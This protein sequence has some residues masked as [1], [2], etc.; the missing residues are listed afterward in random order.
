MTTIDVPF[1]IRNAA[2]VDTT[3]MKHTKDRTFTTRDVLCAR[4][5]IRSK[6]G[7][8]H[9]RVR[10]FVRVVVPDEARPVSTKRAC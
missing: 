9:P 2:M 8:R 4:A 6:M 10:P 1:L 7:W 3:A 5:E